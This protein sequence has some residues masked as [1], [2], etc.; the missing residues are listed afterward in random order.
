VALAPST[1]L[2][3]PLHL[4]WR[5]LGFEEP[6]QEAGSW[7]SSSRT[8]EPWAG[9][10]PG[11]G[12]AAAAAAAAQV[13]APAEQA[14]CAHGLPRARGWRRIS[15]R[16]HAPDPSR[17]GLL[18]LQPAP[19]HVSAVCVQ[20]PGQEAAARLGSPCP[21]SSVSSGG[22]GGSSVI[23]SSS[24]DGGSSSSSSSSGGNVDVR[25]SLSSGSS[26]SA[27]LNGWHVRMWRCVPLEGQEPL[28]APHAQLLASGGG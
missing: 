12:G 18:L 8:G 13:C 3:D 17:Y 24:N 27:A 6:E 28:E 20:L 5:P 9:E 7:P 10:W 15:L 25:G 16:H 26:G 21:S 1:Q 23:L 4:S 14:L 19:E 11:G 22:A 2:N